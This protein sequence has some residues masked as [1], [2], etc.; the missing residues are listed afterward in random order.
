[1]F[2]FPLS[3]GPR[4]G[5]RASPPLPLPSRALRCLSWDGPGPTCARRPPSPRAAFP[6][7]AGLARLS[8][9]RRDGAI[10]R[11]DSRAPEDE[12]R[13]ARASAPNPRVACFSAAVRPAPTRVIGTAP[14]WTPRARRPPSR[15]RARLGPQISH[16]GWALP[17]ARASPPPL[18]PHSPPRMRM[19]YPRGTGL[20]G[21]ARASTLSTRALCFL[22]S[23]AAALGKRSESPSP[24]R[25]G[26]RLRVSP[27]RWAIAI[28]DVRF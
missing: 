19:G 20:A 18:P 27:L 9:A 13:R 24:G 10:L 25:I 12:G 14:S 22:P 26:E 11:G 21:R 5:A 6:H 8:R 4:P 15:E 16:S 7:G 17:R 1:M 2:L 28:A 23:C 3:G